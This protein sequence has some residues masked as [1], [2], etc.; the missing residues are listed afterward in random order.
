[1]NDNYEY[2]R[3]KLEMSTS[4]TK[5]CYVQGP[6]GPKGDMGSQGIRGLPGEK[7][8]PGEMG[9]TGPTGPKGENGPTTINVGTTETVESDIDAQVINGGTEKDVILNFKIPKGTAGDKGDKGEKGDIGPRGLPGEIGR[10]EVITIDATITTDEN[11]EAQVQDDK[12]GLIH[13]LTFYIPQGK[14][15]EQGLPGIQGPKGDAFG[16]NAYG[17]RYSNTNQQFHILANNDT[18]IPLEQTGPSLSTTYDS[19]YTIEVNKSGL[20]LVSYFLNV[21]PSIDVNYIVSIETMG[22]KVPSS[23]IKVEGKANSINNISGSIF[24]NLVEYDEINLTI[25]PEQDAD[26]I[27]DGTT[28]ARLSIIKLD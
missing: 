21:A 10:S 26:L 6:T 24:L 2:I 13:H 14:K 18:I 11:E 12:E 16:V 20:Y 27:F 19:S 22:V 7:G 23:S 1:M 15:G 8:E 25:T 4:N 28:N 9:P 17:E 5:F 3:K